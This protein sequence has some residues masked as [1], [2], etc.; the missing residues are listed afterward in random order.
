VVLT[1]QEAEELGIR[2]DPVEEVA[3][4][5]QQQQQQ[6]HELQQQDEP[7]EVQQV[8]EFSLFGTEPPK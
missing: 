7:V 6:E 3:E 5:E 1:R 4:D 2:L 8:L